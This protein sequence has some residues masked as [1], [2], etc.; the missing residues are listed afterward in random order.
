MHPPPDSN[1][2]VF[3]VLTSPPSNALTL[4]LPHLQIRGT[5]LH[6]CIAKLLD[7][8]LPCIS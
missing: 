7:H 1:F 4:L 3:T 5:A 2:S 8:T 6:K